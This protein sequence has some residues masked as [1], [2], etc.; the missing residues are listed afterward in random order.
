MKAKRNVSALLIA[1]IL[2]ALL[3]VIAHGPARAEENLTDPSIP[4]LMNGAPAGPKPADGSPVPAPL[5]GTRFQGAVNAPTITVWYGPAQTFGPNGDPQKWVNIVGNVSPP[6]QLADLTYTL[7]GGPLRALDWGGS[8]NDN[9]RL[10]EPGD[11]NIDIDYTDLMPG[12]NTVIIT[13]T[14]ATAEVTNATVI[15]NYQNGPVW[16]PGTYTTNWASAAGVQDAAQVV[17]GNWVIDSGGARPAIVGYDRLLAV[18]DLSWRDYTVTVPVTVH[19][20][21][22]NRSPGVGL[23]VRW[24]GHF[25]SG[26]GNQ[27][28]VGW[29]RLGALAW[30]RYQD[31]QPPT[32][33]L[34]LLGHE[35]QELA[36]KPFTLVTGRTYLYKVSIS[37]NPSPDQPATYRFKVWNA[38]Q[39]EPA[40]WDFEEQGRPGE[41]RNGS[42]ILL[43]HHADVSFGNVTVNLIST[44]PKPELTIVMAG[45]GGGAVVADPQRATYRFGEDV[46]LTAVPHAGSTFAGWQGDVEGANPAAVEMFADRNVTAIFDSIAELQYQAYISI[47]QAGE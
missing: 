36:S 6:G 41:P 9:N 23:I 13:A 1:I 42:I 20:L 37:S 14:N 19:S 11:F 15:V 47:V 12:N 45:T 29:R 39:P 10:I 21:N 44:E 40:G 18:G 26:T 32:E 8:G 2:P 25:D 16:T 22:A 4:P 31:G 28:F 33:G 34:Q 43:A 3:I 38:S 30:Y 17:D 46:L 24:M 5:A 7:N 35:G 27:P